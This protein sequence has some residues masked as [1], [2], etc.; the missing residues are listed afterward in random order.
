[1][2]IV[3]NFVGEKFILIILLVRLDIMQPRKLPGNSFF[4]FA[5][6]ANPTEQ[7][8]QADSPTSSAQA[9]A[10]NGLD[11][12]ACQLKASVAAFEE[13]HKD[14]LKMERRRLADAEAR[15]RAIPSWAFD[16]DDSDTDVE[17]QFGVV[18]PG[19]S[20]EQDLDLNLA[21]IQKQALDNPTHLSVGDPS[22][23][24][25]EMKNVELLQVG[26]FRH[27]LSPPQ[28]STHPRPLSDEE[29]KHVVKKA[30]SGMS[31]KH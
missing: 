5:D 19:V 7:N 11:A 22:P 17:E 3:K 20:K 15:L 23:S 29:D 10:T 6:R 14:R 8:A 21:S 9:E 18:N 1:V 27:D 31:P 28:S 13:K 24:I 12:L 25:A 16:S 26:L 2:T 30:R 4:I